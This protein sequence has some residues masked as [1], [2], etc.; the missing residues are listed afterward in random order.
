MSNENNTPV[1]R[2]GLAFEDD[3]PTPSDVVSETTTVVSEPTEVDA[4]VVAD[5][6]D[7]VSHTNEAAAVVEDVSVDEPLSHVGLPTDE[8][9]AAGGSESEEVEMVAVFK[10]T[11]VNPNAELLS[12]PSSKLDPRRKWRDGEAIYVMPCTADEFNDLVTNARRLDPTGSLKGQEWRNAVGLGRETMPSA[13]VG[14][15]ALL[16]EDSL[17][18]Q[19]VRSGG[20]GSAEIAAGRPK[21]SDRNGDAPLVGEEA[22]QYMQVMLGT[23][24]IS[25][26][27]LWH[28]GLWLNLKAPTESQQLELERRIANEK[29]ELGRR[30]SGLAYSNMSVYHNSF[31]FN[32][33]LSMVFDC[34]VSGYTIQSL[35]ERILLPDLPLLLWGMLCT[36]YPNGYRYHRPC[37]NDPS[38]CTHVVEELLDISKLCWTDNTALQASQRKLMI[39]KTAKFTDIELKNYIAQ[40]RYNEKG[41]VVLKELNGNKTVVELRVPTLA[42]YEASGFSW[43]EGIVAGADMAFGSQLGSDE[44]NEYIL[45][46]ARATSLRQ[47]AHWIER[48]TFNG[49]KYI[50]DRTT[51]ETMI[52]Q[53]TGDA[54]VF[55][56]FLEG[57][58]KYINE[59]TISQIAIPSYKCPVCQKD[60]NNPEE[61]KHPHLIPLDIGTIFFILLGQRTS[62]LL[63]TAV[64]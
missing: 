1:H 5:V 6:T 39:K 36:I 33:A 52:G 43:V 47:Y 37:I 2:P 17:W 13:S 45:D 62:L 11:G 46:Q 16:R 3:I 58:R 29:I 19:A 64:I 7:D 30:T 54:E 18:R 44:R 26:I 42:D 25:R 20:E 8:D 4:V 63:D 34:S 55:E 51:L 10:R 23:G 22:L 57:T 48:I 35:K 28:S 53:L 38:V 15:D 9:G 27:P 31:L 14:L 32:F 56:N 24:Q 21:P 61:A 40:H 49:D 59:A 50:D 41:T 60:Q 12:D